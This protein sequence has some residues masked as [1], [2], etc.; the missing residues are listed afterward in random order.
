MYLNLF[1]IRLF[2]LL[3]YFITPNQSHGVLELTAA[4]ITTLP[5]DVAH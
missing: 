4:S 5:T 1:S 2:E 3:K